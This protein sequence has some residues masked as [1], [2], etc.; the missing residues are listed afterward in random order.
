MAGNLSKGQAGMIA[1]KNPTY[2]FTVTLADSGDEIANFRGYFNPES[3]TDHSLGD[4]A[5]LAV[6][7]AMYQAGYLPDSVTRLN[8]V[9]NL[10]AGIDIAFSPVDDGKRVRVTSSRIA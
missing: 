10:R 6:S 1:S 4:A 9:A 2:D 8:A 5:E 3:E 7:Y